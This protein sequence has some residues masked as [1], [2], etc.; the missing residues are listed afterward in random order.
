M[1]GWTGK[2]LH[3]DL[4]AKSFRSENLPLSVYEKY[5]GGKGLAGSYLHENI[6]RPWDSP[7]MPLLFINGPLVDTPSPA[8]GRMTVMSRSPLTGTICDASVGGRFGTRLKKA[9][10]DGIVITGAS[11]TWCGIEIR[12]GDLRFLPA[13]HLAGREISQCRIPDGDAASTAII[14]PAAENGVLF[15]DIVIDGH[16]FAGRGGLGLV[17]AGKKIKYISVSGTGTTAIHDGGEMAK[18]REEIFRLTSAS[19]A[20]KGALGIAEFGTGALYDLMHSRRMMPTDNF[21]STFFLQ[22]PEMN[23]WR[24]RDRFGT[25][26]TGCAGCHIMCK[27][28]GG[29]GSVIP[30]FETMSHFSALVG[31]TDM[32]AVMEANRLCNETGMDTISTAGTIACYCELHA[33]R[34]SPAELISL[35]KDIAYSRGDGTRLGAGSYR[36]AASLGKP[37]LSMSVKKL[38]LPAYDPRGAFGMALAYVTSTRGGCHLRAYPIS[39][40]ILRKPV[41][42]SRFTFSGKAR[43]IKISEDMHSMVDSLTS[44][45]FLF[46]AATLEEYAR[47]LCGVTGS[48]FTAQ[49]L[50]RSGERTY[51]AERMMNARNGFTSADDDLPPRFF[52]EPGSGTPEMPIPPLDRDAFLRARAD[53]YRI[54]G[55]DENGMPAEA[56]MNE[57]GIA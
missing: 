51:Y 17:M 27:K 49:D 23:A 16:F 21:R 31:N 45:K 32:D 18:A 29:D 26:K 57:L 40:E 2:I 28:T 6:T 56:R 15:A 1:F 54:R 11:E 30:E 13:D 35:I 47:A 34:L 19:P 38:E 7:G 4:G 48:A 37:E 25:R 46:F 52:T 22:A 50:V 3:V 9:G 12:D 44:C 43:I 33:L 5:V 10:W 55:L 41:A 39:H 53:Y 8:S 24:Y 20:L 42:T 36:Y 14:G